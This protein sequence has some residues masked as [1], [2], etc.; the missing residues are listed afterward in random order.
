MATAAQLAAI[1]DELRNEIRNEIR[2]ETVAAAAGTPDAIRRKPEIPAFDKAHIDIWIRRMEHAYTRAGITSTSDKFAWLET[3][4]PVGGDPKID[5]FLY[6]ETTTAE[7][8]RFL[9]YL[10]KEYGM[11][12]QQKASIFLDGFK[13]DGRRPSQYAAILDEKTKDVTIDDIKKEMLLREMPPDVRR[14]LQERIETQSVREAAQIADSYFDAE[15]RPKHSTSTNS[16]NEITSQLQDAEIDDNDINA[17]DRRMPPKQNR[18][19]SQ[20]GVPAVN[21][22]KW[23]RPAPMPKQQSARREQTPKNMQKNVNLCQSHYKFG[24]DAWY[25]E[26]GC[27][28]YSEKRSSGNGPA[29]RK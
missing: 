9:A 23:N 1:H 19:P 7:W 8:N 5:E 21:S 10:R 12:K 2:A 18:F 15:G 22:Q 27:S 14:M 17:V 29:G 24:N 26:E 25:C 11:T 13:R 16:V 28:R 3:K 20:R 6:G 4:F